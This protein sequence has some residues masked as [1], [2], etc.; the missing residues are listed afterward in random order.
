MT[1]SETFEAFEVVEAVDAVEVFDPQAVFMSLSGQ[2]FKGLWSS[3]Q[4]PG[5]RGAHVFVIQLIELVTKSSEENAREIWGCLRREGFL[6]KTGTHDVIYRDYSYQGGKPNEIVDLLTALEVLKTLPGKMKAA[7]RI[8]ASHLLLRFLGGDMEILE[9][10][11]GIRQLHDFLIGLNE[12]DP[13]CRW[14]D[15]D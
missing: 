12:N 4:V 11:W 5:R 9:K 3:D 2:D 8:W 14:I 1:S 15:V 6:S 13:D 10:L 7:E